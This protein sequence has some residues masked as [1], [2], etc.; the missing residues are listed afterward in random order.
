[1]FPFDRLSALFLDLGNTLVSVDF[2]WVCDELARRGVAA[3]ESELERAEAAAR[4]RVSEAV[5]QAGRAEGADAFRRYLTSVLG[6]VASAAD[7]PE[8]DRADLA[9]DLAPVLRVPGET[10]RLWCD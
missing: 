9:A 2:A 10:H 8:R 6:V 3:T 5:R 1:M 7:M 4:P